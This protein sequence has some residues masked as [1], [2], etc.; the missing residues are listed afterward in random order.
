M[1]FSRIALALSVAAAALFAVPFGAQAQSIRTAEAP[2]YNYVGI[3]GGDNGFSVN[4]KFSVSDN[5]SIRPEVATDFNFNDSEDVSYLVPITYDFNTIGQG[6][7]AFNPFV[8]AGVSGD[9]GNNSNVDFTTVVGTDYRFARN[10]VANG[11][12]NYSPFANDN[13][14][15]FNLGVARAF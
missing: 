5:V 8:G 14:V 10:Y 13:E 3:G 7:A 2:N 4:G 1:K 12:I 11:S 9:I 15:G 6:R